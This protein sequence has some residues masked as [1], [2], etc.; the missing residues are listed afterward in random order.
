MRHPISLLARL[1]VFAGALVLTPDCAS[2]D[3]SPEQGTSGQD[4]TGQDTTG[5]T[6][7]S[8]GDTEDGVLLSAA[9]WTLDWDTE[10]VVFPEGGG[11]EWE[12]DLGY[13]VHVDDGRIL[14]HSV[15]FGPC[16][17][18]SSGATGS[19]GGSWFGG[20][21][22]REA[23]PWGLGGWSL[24]VRSARAHA[25]SA[26]PS[27]IET[28]LVEDLTSPHA[29]DFDTSFTAARHCRAHYLLARPM[30]ATKGPDDV[31][32]EQRSLYVTGTYERGGAMEPFVIDTWWPQ[33][34]LADLDG[35]MPSEA[36]ESARASG[37]AHHAF[38]TVTRHL[39]A[40]F[41]GIDFEA[42][43]EDQVAGLAVDNLVRGVT[44]EVELW[45]PGGE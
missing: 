35:A 5:Q 16:D 31:S 21:G 32:M 25:D 7:S 6:T 30:A 8:G 17:S 36:Y 41:D 37:T 23:R 18:A 20:R 19:L 38:V 13:R 42:A 3:E 40:L 24:G 14:S 26:D 43:T 2:P 29:A 11:A 15:A 39:G 34:N 22:A 9:I 44:F 12:T 4:T 10:G 45:A 27:T 1:A 28:S 33:G